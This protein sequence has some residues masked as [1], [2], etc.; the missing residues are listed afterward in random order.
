MTVVWD[1]AKYLQ[2]ANERGR[3]FVDLLARVGATEPAYVVDLGCG[4]GNLTATLLDR[5]PNAY[6]QGVD[7]SAEMITTA[8][9]LSQPGRLEFAVGDLRAWTPPRPVDVLVSNATL[10]WVP[11]HLGLLARLLS[12][13]RP[14]G[15]FAFQVPG[16]AG[17]RTHTAI[18]ELLDLPRWQDQLDGGELARPSSEE[19][20]TYLE[21]LLAL[22]ARADVW[23]TTYLQVLTGPDAVVRWMSGTGLRPVLGALE[24]R[25]REEFLAAYRELVAATYPERAVGTVLSYRR[26]FA[27]AQR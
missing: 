10:Q 11:G 16:N 21:T 19:P 26:I 4:P 6:V 15:S 25:E 13:V 27:V 24:A 9:P 5:W 3:P 23:E 2:F 7:S 1:P 8:L 22:G 20:T 18:T 12:A 14:G 17:E